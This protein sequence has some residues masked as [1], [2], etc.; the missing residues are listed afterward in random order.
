MIQP[1][2]FASVIPEFVF[3]AKWRGLAVHGQGSREIR[4]ERERER[5]ARYAG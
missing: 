2:P 5:L 1:Q 3:S 4:R